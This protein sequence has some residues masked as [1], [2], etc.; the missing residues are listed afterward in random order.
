MESL[1]ILLQKRFSGRMYQQRK[2]EKEKIEYLLECA[3]LSPSAVNYQPWFFY[4]IQAEEVKE[5]ICQAYQRDWFKQADC[6]IIACGNHKEGWKRVDGKDSTEID[7]SIACTAICLAAEEIGL[8]TCW[9]GN[10]NED[11]VRKALDLPEELEVVAIFPLGY[12]AS[13]I[14]IPEK[15]RK[16]LNDIV[17]WK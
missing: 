6:Y 4:V 11:I 7:V 9:V 13:D 12:P 2:I 14:K 17:E 15:K 1:K 10:F 8:A 5:K 3:R 16:D